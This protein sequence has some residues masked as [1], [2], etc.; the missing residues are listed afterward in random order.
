MIP[1]AA[2]LCL[3]DGPDVVLT[4]ARP[5]AGE[6]AARD[7]ARSLR[8]H[9][10]RASVRVVGDKVYLAVSSSRWPVE[11]VER[12]IHLSGLALARRTSGSHGRNGWS[13]TWRVNP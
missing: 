7:L 2:V 12:A 1:L 4:A 13:A 11:Q 3:G 10:C 9:D 6:I 8:R 5:G